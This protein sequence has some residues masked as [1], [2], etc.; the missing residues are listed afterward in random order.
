MKKPRA[1][2]TTAD[3]KPRGSSGSQLSEALYYSL[4]IILGMR[5]ARRC[6]IAAATMGCGMLFWLLG[7]PIPVIILLA[8]LL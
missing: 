5:R 2:A 3:R 1:V 7:I 8:L 6:C 4:P